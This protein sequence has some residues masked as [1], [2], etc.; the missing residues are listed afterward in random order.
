LQELTFRRQ[1]VSLSAPH[2]AIYVRQLLEEQFGAEKV[3]NG[4]LRVTTTL[5]LNYQH[6]AEELARRHVDNVGPEHNMTNAAMVV[7]RPGT[8]EILSMLGSVDYRDESI[9]GNVNVTLSPQQPGSAIKPVTYAAALSPGADGSDPPL[10]AGDILWDV[11]V[12]YPQVD[13]T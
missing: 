5:D 10:T 13:G 12:D 9:D 7:L 11:R 1:E 4:G 3:A 8:G 2:F 6:L